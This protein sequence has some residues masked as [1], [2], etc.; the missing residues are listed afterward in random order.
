[1]SDPR[2][3]AMM[4]SLKKT[5]YHRWVQSEGLPL[6]EGHGLED[7]LLTPHPRF[8]YWRTVSGKEV[9]LVIEHGRRLVAVEIKLTS[10][11]SY[12][13]TEALQLFLEDYLETVAA[14]LIHTGREVKRLH[15]KIV[16][17]PWYLLSGKS[18]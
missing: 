10:A 1:M 18:K 8:S 11:P 14:L 9:D 17:I 3:T 12:R 6:V 15:E 4:E 13:D 2:M 7:V 5:P 16:A